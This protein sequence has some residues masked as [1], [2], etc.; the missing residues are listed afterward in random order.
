MAGEIY[1]YIYQDAYIVIY[2][3]IYIYLS[4]IWWAYKQKAMWLPVEMEYRILPD[5]FQVNMLTRLHFVKILCMTP[6]ISQNR[7]K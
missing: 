6:N 7:F 3:I 1:I 5:S 2:N 4:A